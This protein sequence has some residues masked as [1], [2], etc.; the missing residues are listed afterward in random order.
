MDTR[1]HSLNTKDIVLY[2]ET[3]CLAM[4]LLCISVGFVHAIFCCTWN[5]LR[6]EGWTPWMEIWLFYAALALLA[7]TK[8]MGYVAGRSAP[9]V[10]T[11]EV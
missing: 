3:W 11:E 1:H 4:R 9:L 10:K 7:D 8:F 2:T 6:N 5:V